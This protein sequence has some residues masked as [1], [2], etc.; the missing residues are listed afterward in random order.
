MSKSQG[1]LNP[2]PSD[3]ITSYYYQNTDRKFFRNVIT[4]YLLSRVLCRYTLYLSNN[5][6]T[7]TTTSL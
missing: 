1:M 2:R 7:L 4:L 3:Y 5:H 6:Y